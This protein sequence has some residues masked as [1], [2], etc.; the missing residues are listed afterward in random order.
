MTVARRVL[1]I[2]SPQIFPGTVANMKN[3]NSL[4]VDKIKDAVFAVKKLADLPSQILTLRRKGAA[5]R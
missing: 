5:L 1:Y 4:V 3:V 2:F